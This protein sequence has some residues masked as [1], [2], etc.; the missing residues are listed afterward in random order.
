MTISSRTPEGKPSR[1]PLCGGE[2]NIDYSV[3]GQDATCPKCGCLI[4][5]SAQLLDEFQ[6]L[7]ERLPGKE[8]GCID[9]SR[10]FDTLT[11]DSLAAVEWVMQLEE[12]FG[13]SIPEDAADNIQTVADL[14]RYILEHHRPLGNGE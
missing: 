11:V 6:N 1:C 3:L 13:L 14:I 2:T 7:C 8:P 12:A 9:P 4:S 5:L 10:R